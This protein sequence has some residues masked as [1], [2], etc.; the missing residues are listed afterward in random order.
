MQALKTR[1]NPRSDEFRTNADAMRKLVEELG[2]RLC[3]G[4]GGYGRG[5]RC[6]RVEPVTLMA[7]PMA[8]AMGS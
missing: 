5:G 8:W 2:A 6:R 3:H 7:P 4:A 1:I